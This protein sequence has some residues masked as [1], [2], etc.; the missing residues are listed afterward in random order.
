MQNLMRSV[1]NKT[2]YMLA[3]DCEHWWLSWDEWQKAMSGT[4]DWGDVRKITPAWLN[5]VY[6]HFMAMMKNAYGDKYTIWNYTAKWFVDGYAPDMN[7]WLDKYLLWSADYSDVH[8]RFQGII[9][10]DDPRDIRDYMPQSKPNL[11]N[12]LWQFTGD[13]FTIPQVTDTMGRPIAM[14]FNVYRKGNLDQFYSLIGFDG[15]AV[16]PPA[17]DDP[18]DPPV[19]DGPEEPPTNDPPAS[20]D[21]LERIAVALERIADFFDK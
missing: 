10:L 3:C 1:S 7:N 12:V 9:N 13:K 17:N 4:M 20:N 6:S 18:E 16:E 21:V 5:A 2:F 19:N 14:D 8:N 11:D 15:G